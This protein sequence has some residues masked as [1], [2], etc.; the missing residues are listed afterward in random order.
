MKIAIVGYG[1]MG[2]AVEKVARANGHEIVATV[3]AESDWKDK[4]A[5]LKTA[6]VAIEFT[7][8]ATAAESIKRCFELNIPVVTGSTAWE[9]D[10]PEILRLCEKENQALF[11]SSNFSLGVNIFFKLNRQ[12]AAMMDQFDQYKPVIEETHHIKKVDKPSGTARVLAGDLVS[13]LRRIKL[14]TQDEKAKNDELAVISHRSEDVPGTHVVRYSSAED[15]IEIKHIAKSREGFARGA[16]M[17]AEWL[18]GKEGF[19]TMDDLLA[20]VI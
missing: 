17:A 5:Q 6:D 19:F 1:R 4:A 3:D 9:D 18:P 12:L 13:A 11:K 10:F 15:V 8:P 7:T 2:K 16:V 20:E 14:W